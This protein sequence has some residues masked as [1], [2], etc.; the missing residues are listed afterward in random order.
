MADITTNA[1]LV[2]MAVAGICSRIHQG[3]TAGSAAPGAADLFLFMPTMAGSPSGQIQNGKYAN[4]RSA[5]AE[6]VS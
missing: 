6:G 5:V 1:I 3:K 4:D 2:F